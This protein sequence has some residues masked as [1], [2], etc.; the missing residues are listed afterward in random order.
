M[1]LRTFRFNVGATTSPK[2]AFPTI[3]KPMW[4]FFD[5]SSRKIL[6]YSLTEITQWRLALSRSTEESLDQAFFSPKFWRILGS[7]PPVDSV[8]WEI[9]EFFHKIAQFFWQNSWFFFIN[10]SVFAANTN[11]RCFMDQKCAF[12]TFFT[13]IRLK[14]RLKTEFFPLNFPNFPPVDWVFSFK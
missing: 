3:W 1:L 11:Y 4:G 7:K 14:K 13:P 12:C 9:S 5:K 10:V 8:F 2:M 6:F